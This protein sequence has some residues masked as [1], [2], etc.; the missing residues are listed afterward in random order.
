[1]EYKLITPN[2]FED[3]VNHLRE[4][5]FADEPLNKAAGL[6]KKGTGNQDLEHHSY[7]T[8]ADNLSLMAVNEND[9]VSQTI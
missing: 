2:R 5:F 9:E 1:M 7:E 3:V 8:L 6:C 4:S